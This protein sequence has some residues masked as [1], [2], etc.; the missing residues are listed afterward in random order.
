MKLSKREKMEVKEDGKS[1]QRRR[2]FRVFR[3]QSFASFEEYIA[4]L[5]DL[6][7]I[8]KPRQMRAFVHYTDVRL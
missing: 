5:D 3:S 1:P 2:L 7:S 6:S 8:G 4:A